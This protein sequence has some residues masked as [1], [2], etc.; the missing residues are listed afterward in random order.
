MA[1][2]TCKWSILS[3]GLTMLTLCNVCL[4]Q[5]QEH[6]VYQYNGVDA[7]WSI[8][9]AK[10]QVISESWN[11]KVACPYLVYMPEKD[12]VLM[13]IGFC[14]YPKG[15]KKWHGMLLSSDNHG[16]TWTNPRYL[17]TNK[18]GEPDTGPIGGLTYID[19]GHLLVDTGTSTWYSSDY[20]QVWSDPVPISPTQEGGH[21]YG[22][23]RY[24]D[25]DPTTGK[26]TTLWGSG[27]SKVPDADSV[28]AY[29]RYSNDGGRTLSPSLMVPQW[30]GVNEVRLIR[31][32]NGDLVAAGRIAPPE[33]YKGRLDHYA[34]LGVSISKDNGRTWS[35]MDILY[36][37]GRHHQS[38]VLLPNGHIVMSHVVRLGYT[39]ADDGLPRFGVEAI[40]S[41]D[42]G[43]TWDLDHKYILAIWKGNKTGENYW[44]SSSQRSTSILLPN[45]SILTGFG[46]GYRN[47]DH[48]GGFAPRDIAVVHWRPNNDRLN[49][50]RTIANAPFDSNLRNIFD[51]SDVKDTH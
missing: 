29:L 34:G 17:H 40:V 32:A 41:R 50:N 26:A 6:E 8:L 14:D 21:W 22:E 10:F 27:W 37:W 9:P 42:H 13:G 2:H 11:R 35:R 1:E 30:F 36:E 43:Q 24:V 28:Q 7:D 48:P 5:W 39:D 47:Q 16:T 25:I 23:K 19:Q 4:A 20:G 15:P 51:A 46:T 44:W 49:N 33:K 3:M 31:A 18:Q 38:M 45:G 12:R